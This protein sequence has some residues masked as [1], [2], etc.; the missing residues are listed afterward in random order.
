MDIILQENDDFLVQN[1]ITKG[2]MTLVDEN[3]AD[4]LLSKTKNKPIIAPGGSA[5]NTTIGLGRLSK[6]AVFAGCCGDDDLGRQFQAA[7]SK[8]NVLSSLT[9]TSAAKTGRVVS[10]VTPDAQRSMLTY[11]GASGLTNPDLFTPQLFKGA[12]LVHIEGYLIFNE[13]LLRK[14]LESAK[15]SGVTVSLDLA[16]FNVIEQN[17]NLVK[18]LVSQYVD[19]VLANEDEAKAYTTKSD[20]KEALDIIAED[21][22][23]AVVKLGKRG[24]LVKRDK[25]V[26]TIAPVGEE[27]A[28][29]TTGAGDLWASGFLYGIIN[30]LPIEKAGYIGSL[31]GYEVCRV[32]GAHIPDD[33]WDAILREV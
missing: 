21:C 13:K 11:L 10:V 18:S 31:C 27:K 19:I 15:L 5:C 17:L 12:S 20:E 16:S 23:I 33:R 9:I 24:S 3:Y 30:D 14:V 29:D 22:D 28:K 8:N 7:L 4:N 6:K 25:N 2:A 26:Y 32:F 1:E